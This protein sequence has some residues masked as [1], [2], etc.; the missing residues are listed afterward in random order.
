[1]EYSLCNIPSYLYHSRK[2]FYPKSRITVLAS[3][4]LI[5]LTSMPLVLSITK[6]EPS[7]G[8]SH[9]EN[10]YKRQS[11]EGERGYASWIQYSHPSCPTGRYTGQVTF[12][13]DGHE[14]VPDGNGTFSCVSESENSNSQIAR[15]G[16]NIQHPSRV[17]ESYTG[18]WSD[19]LRQGMGVTTYADGDVYSGQYTNDQR[20]G[21]G[22]MLWALTSGPPGS[23]FQRRYV[24]QYVEG[25]RQGEGEMRF[26]NG[27]LYTGDW[28]NNN[29]TGK[30]LYLFQDSGNR[31]KGDY[32]DN[33]KEGEGI[34]WWTSGEHAG[35]KYEGQFNNDLRQG[36]GIYRY[37]NGDIYDGDWVNG[38]QDGDGI[39]MYA[40]GDRLEGPW[41]NGLREGQMIFT[42]PSGERYS[43]NFVQGE[44][45]GEWTQLETISPNNNPS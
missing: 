13:R 28:V 36:Q 35:D 15:R 12:R 9:P 31:Y 16:A 45:Q 4:T 10:R 44:R 24:G 3:W 11:P 38:N 20:H 6:L 29:R 27:D 39:F 8:L 21:K 30:G 18:A 41:T 26:P 40:N 17:F 37:S 1:M 7:Q 23:M 34:F 5:V 33:R 2:T 14:A 43:A 25:K 42:Q 22:D 19:G 32:V